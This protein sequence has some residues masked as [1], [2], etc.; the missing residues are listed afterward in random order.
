MAH[1]SHRPAHQL[2]RRQY[3]TFPLQIDFTAEHLLTHPLNALEMDFEP[4]NPPPHRMF[5]PAT[6]TVVLSDRPKIRKPD[7][8]VARPG[9]GGYT[10]ASDLK[11]P[12]GLYGKV[13]HR[14]AAL[15]TKHMKPISLSNQ[16]LEAIKTVCDEA[17]KSFPV[18]LD[19]ED[20][21]VTRDM[22]KTHLKNKAQLRQRRHDVAKPTDGKRRANDVA[23]PESVKRKKGSH[24]ESR[25][26]LKRSA[27]DEEAQD[28]SND[29]RVIKRM[30]VQDGR[31]IV[32][33]RSKGTSAGP[34]ESSTSQ[35]L[36]SVPSSAPSQ[37]ITTTQPTSAEDVAEVNSPKPRE[38]NTQQQRKR[39]PIPVQDKTASF[40][41]KLFACAGDWDVI[42]ALVFQPPAPG[43]LDI[44]S[45]KKL[46]GVAGCLQ[47]ID[48]INL[49]PFHYYRPHIVEHDDLEELLVNG[50]LRVVETHACK[51]C[52]GASAAS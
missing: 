4:E 41:V 19:Y 34:P 27:I 29:P 50:Y 51:Y 28:V 31:T 10:L 44:P 20:H 52:A 36:T 49:K 26:R 37:P 39:L 12:D 3:S 8:E 14:V 23:G 45:L 38:R 43:D 22:L 5:D 1:L 17:A 47:V 6:E 46:L 2:V 40:T 21:W 7:G 32:L 15:A 11:W 16:P 18:L 42:A 9:R 13:Q 25:T 33:V 48:P 30:R 35:A 24:S